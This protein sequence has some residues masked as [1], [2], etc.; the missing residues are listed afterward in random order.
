MWFLGILFPPSFI[1][2][3]FK[4]F[5]VTHEPFSN[6]EQWKVTL[7]FHTSTHM[8][9]SV[10]RANKATV[11]HHT[12]NFPR[13]HAD[14]PG[15]PWAIMRHCLWSVVFRPDIMRAVI[16]PFRSG[17]AECCGER[18]GPLHSPTLPWLMTVLATLT[19]RDQRSNRQLLHNSA[20]ARRQP[21]AA[22]LCL[23]GTPDASKHTS[24]QPSE[25]TGVDLLSQKHCFCVGGGRVST[26]LHSYKV[27][28]RLLFWTESFAHL[29]FQ[30]SRCRVLVSA[31]SFQP[32]VLI[33][34]I[35]FAQSHSPP[36][37]FF[38]P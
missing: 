19:E 22:L 38:W 10:S 21:A 25:G 27:D 11:P 14:R 31:S 3:K 33:D 16:L 30:A 6:T 18:G 24:A 15:W 35:R 7:V 32:P 13:V 20:A 9:V 1:S 37:I 4:P 5:I 36:F 26:L 34:A 28:A 23:T 17:R 2:D 12:I 29:C 8:L